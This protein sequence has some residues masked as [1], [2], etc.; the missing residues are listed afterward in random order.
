MAPD[1]PP[2]TPARR[3]FVWETV[4]LNVEPRGGVPRGVDGGAT[5]GPPTASVCEAT[6]AA[7]SLQ[8]FL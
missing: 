1:G 5:V 4:V 8:C 3:R 6:G 7:A 2:T